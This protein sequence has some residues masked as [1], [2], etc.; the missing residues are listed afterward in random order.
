LFLEPARRCSAERFVLAGAQYPENFDWAPNIFFLWHLPPQEHP[1]FFCSSRLTLNVTRAAMREMGWCP[2]GRLFEAAACRVPVISDWWEG[3]DDFFEPG[4][5]ILIAS[6]T[7]DVVT[8]LQ[9]SDA[10]LAAIATAA[11]ER[12]LSE[13]TGF[14]RVLQLEQLLELAGRPAV[15]ACAV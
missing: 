10:E 6:S 13:H 5:E 1:T 12:T 15:A 4:S 7:D 8:A 14:H 11:R 3:L 9:L 2:S